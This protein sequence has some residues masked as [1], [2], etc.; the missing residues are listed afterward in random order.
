MAD[1]TWPFGKSLTAGDAWIWTIDLTPDYSADDYTLKI[2]LRGNQAGASLDIT[3][4]ASGTSF[5][6]SVPAATTS[7]LPAGT[8][9]WQVVVYDASNNPL[10]LGRGSLDILASLSAQTAPVDDRS[11]NKR[12]LDAIRANIEGRAS[13]VEQEYQVGGRHL[14]LMSID[15]LLNLE[16]VFAAR[17]RREAI[18]SGQA[19]PQSN[20]VHF[21]F[22]PTT[23]GAR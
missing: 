7:P 12:I 18:E 10:E 17:V 15:D 1:L 23:G 8:Y 11:Q 21:R 6:V 5:A 2:F 16:G 14:R 19:G 13:R 4:T 22:Y 20:N 9:E 3:A